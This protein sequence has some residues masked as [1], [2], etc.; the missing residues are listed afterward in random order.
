MHTK[1]DWVTMSCGNTYLTSIFQNMLE[2]IVIK[3]L[4]ITR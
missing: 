4:L 1:E 2:G 3:K